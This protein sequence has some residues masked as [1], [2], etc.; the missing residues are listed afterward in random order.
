MHRTLEIYE[1]RA[2]DILSNPKLELLSVSDE[3]GVLR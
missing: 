2:A 1:V 3:A